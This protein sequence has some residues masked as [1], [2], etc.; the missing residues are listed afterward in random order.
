MHIEL[1]RAEVV[2]LLEA[3]DAFEIRAGVKHVQG[4]AIKSLVAGKDMVSMIREASAEA[5]RKILL[6]AESNLFL[7]AKLVQ[8]RNRLSEHDVADLKSP[9]RDFLN[10]Q[11]KQP[12]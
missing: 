1:S 7:R 6:A 10:R 12:L 5:D 9:P 11:T 4:E 8:Y 3:L 2:T